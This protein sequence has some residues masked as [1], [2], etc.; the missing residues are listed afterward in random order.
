MDDLDL[1]DEIYRCFVERGGPPT[2]HEVAELTGG[3]DEARTALRRLH[4]AHM[5]VLG[6]DGEIRM[7][8]PFAARP[9][10]HRVVT[11]DGRSWWANCAWD[12]LAI[13]VAMGIDAR[14]EAT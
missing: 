12:A 11:D 1:R 6:A 2:V 9:T 13:P 8:L 14:I 4:D 10:E 3:V 7:A 5:A